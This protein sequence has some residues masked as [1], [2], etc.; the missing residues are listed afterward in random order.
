MVVGTGIQL[1][2]QLTPETQDEFVGAD[3]LLFVV[4]DPA[5]DCGSR[6]VFEGTFAQHAVPAWPSTTPDLRQMVAEIL[7]PLRRGSR[8]CAAFYG[9]PGVFVAPSHEAIR[10]ARPGLSRPDAARSVGRELPDRRPRGRPRRA[11]LAELEA[12][13]L[14]WRAHSRSNRSGVVL[15]QVDA[16]GKLTWNLDPEPHGLR[17]LGEHLL[18]ALPT[19]TRSSSMPRSLYPVAD[20]IIEPVR[21]DALAEL[22]ATPGPTLY[23]PPLPPDRRPRHRPATRHHTGVTPASRKARAQP[24]ETRFTLRWSRK[25]ACSAHSLDSSSSPAGAEHVPEIEQRVA[26]EVEQVGP[27][28]PGER[29]AADRLPRRRSAPSRRGRASAWARVPGTCDGMSSSDA[30]GLHDRGELLRLP[31]APEPVDAGDSS[32]AT[33]AR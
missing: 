20:A 2:R 19:G 16:V 23:V 25:S 1:L 15:W 3:E 29:V 27:L 33:L 10:Q 12:T 32:A 18:G 13:R 8:V 4:A 5:L 11:R 6:T 9:H 31:G 22:G 24:A 26:V 30:V 17:V 14:C 28:D 7:E 21:L